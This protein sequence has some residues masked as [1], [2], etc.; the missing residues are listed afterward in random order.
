MVART[1]CWRI[2]ETDVQWLIVARD[3][4]D[5]QAQE[6]RMAARRPS[7]RTAQ[8]QARGTCWSAARSSTMTA[9]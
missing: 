1:S 5:A 3:G 4:T 6:R 2:G 9:A 7:R 8:L